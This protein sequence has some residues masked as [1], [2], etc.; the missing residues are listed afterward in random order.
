MPRTITPYLLYE[1]AGAAIEFLVEAFGFTE[2]LRFTDEDGRV[3]HAELSLGDG[4]IMLGAPGGDFRSP[5]R[6]GPAPSALVHVYVEDVDTHFA[7][8]RD[9]GATILSEPED[10]PYGDRSYGVEDPEGQLV[11][12]PARPRGRARGVGAQ[13]APARG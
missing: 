1:D 6:S 11:L 8:A 2:R 13:T 4:S 10:K 3:T 9:A 5:K 12:L 7:H